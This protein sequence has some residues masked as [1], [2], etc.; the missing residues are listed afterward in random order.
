MV[1]PHPRTKICLTPSCSPVPVR[2]MPATPEAALGIQAYNSPPPVVR[3]ERLAD[4]D[5]HEL[6][7]AGKIDP[8]DLK[9][10]G[11]YGWS[12]C[13]WAGQRGNIAMFE[14]LW[15][16]GAGCMIN[17]PRRTDGL[18]PVSWATTDAVST[19]QRPLPAID[20]HRN[21]PQPSTSHPRPFLSPSRPP[22]LPPAVA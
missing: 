15:S 2:S 17:A 20:R 9:G 14:W 10:F 21:R 22:R 3:V 6:L 16:Q 7:D 18:T 1:T 12:A 19:D 11:S 5:A 4:D 8:T 13:H